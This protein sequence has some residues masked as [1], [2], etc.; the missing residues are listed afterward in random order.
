MN[1]K[2]SDLQ[3]NVALNGESIT[4]KLN[5]VTDFEDFSSNEDEQKG[6]FLVIK[7]DEAT[8]GKTV[9]AELSE[10]KGEGKRTLDED[11]IIVA[12]ITS[13]TQTITITIENESKILKLNELELDVQ[14]A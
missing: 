1:K 3:E 12:R 10:A 2:V 6:N 4:G 11:G 14:S 13:K 5:Y 8:K 9:T 7:V